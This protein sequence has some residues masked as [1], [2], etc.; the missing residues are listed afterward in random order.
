VKDNFEPCLVVILRNEG[1]KVD[2]PHDP[3]GR[4]N[5]GV[6]Q[7][8]YDDYRKL[9][10][11]ATRDVYTITDEE[12]RYIYKGRYW[13]VIGADTLPKGLDLAT[14][15]P[16]VNSGPGKAKQWLSMARAK[17]SDVGLQ[18]DALC[19]FRLSFLHCLGTWKHFGAGWARRVADV[20]ARSHAMARG[21]NAAP[22]LRQKAQEATKKADNAAATATASGSVGGVGTASHAATGGA[23]VETWIVVALVTVCVAGVVYFLWRRSQHNATADALEA[24]AKEV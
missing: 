4:T 5:R 6:T 8:T 23:H 21:V 16:C 20:R 24:V 12:V 3:G 11:L 19:D 14:F 15:D 9:K 7:H 22:V 1:G 10:G 2:N 13:D 18:I 17:A